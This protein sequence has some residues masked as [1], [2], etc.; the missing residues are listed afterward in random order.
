MKAMI[1][2]PI[3]CDGLK[4]VAKSIKQDQKVNSDIKSV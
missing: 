1:E 2:K 3:L 4:P